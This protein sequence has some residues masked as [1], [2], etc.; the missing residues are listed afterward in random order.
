MVNTP[1]TMLA[2]GTQAPAFQ[3]PD[4]VTGESVSLESFDTKKGLLVMF[5]WLLGAISRNIDLIP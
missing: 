2:L 5:I 3:L 4:V 1:S